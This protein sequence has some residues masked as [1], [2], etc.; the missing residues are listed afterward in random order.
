MES[1]SNILWGIAV[2]IFVVAVATVVLRNGS[3]EVTTTV[4]IGVITPLTGVRAEAGEFSR[5]AILIAQDEINNADRKYK[6][7]F[8]F[9]D[10]KYEP[11]VAVGAIKKL[12]DLD[13]TSYIMGNGGSSETLAIAPIAEQSKIVLIVSGAQSDE[14]SKAGDYI[15]RIIHNTSQETPSSGKLM[16]SKMKGTNLSVLG[17][18]TDITP[19]YVKNLTPVLESYGKK[20]ITLEKFDTKSVDF[21]TQLLKL[22]KQKPTDILIIGTPKQE[23]MIMKQASELGMGKIQYYSI[24]LEGPELVGTAGKL[25]DGLLY[26]YSYDSESK[27]ENVRRFHE[28]YFRRYGKE[29]DTMA[30]NSYDAA[31]LLSNCFEKVGDDVEKVKSCLYETKDYKGASGTF[32]IDSN[33]D[34]IKQFV[35][36][37]VKDGK[38]VKY[39]E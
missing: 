3:S 36:K 17:M 5:N 12:K 15:F 30:A 11:A 33:G 1:K 21:R 29:N 19:S 32:S 13:N 18:N 39:S 22:N 10:S 9:E 20:I 7:Q 35:V 31:Y 37:T 6:M 27:D 28:E 23:G 8:I 38:Y 26:V 34:A 14:I 24:G 16:A 2:V 4:K 25:A